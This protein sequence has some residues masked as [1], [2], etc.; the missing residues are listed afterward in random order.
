MAVP[1]LRAAEAPSSASLE[2]QIA[3]LESELLQAQAER[4]RQKQQ[5]EYAD[6]EAIKLRQ[7]AK[8]IEK[9]LIDTRRAYADHML[10]RHEN[11]RTLEDEI[12]ALF[13][14][15]SDAQQEADAIRNEVALAGQKNAGAASTLTA[16]LEDAVT[17]SKD[18]QQQA[19]NK[20]KEFNASRDAAAA[21]DPESAALRKR[22]NELDGRHREAFA[23]LNQYL[24]QR[25]E[26]KSLDRKRMDIAG[27]L[28]DVKKQ[29]GAA[30][31]APAGIQS[32]APAP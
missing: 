10:V 26:I 23:K 25:E 28:A 2:Q 31:A 21:A 29:L 1:L 24:D 13:R 4:F 5:L 3:A 15:S 16:E 30:P 19:I 7:V 17:R 6:P 20:T 18:L 8:T 9:D 14:A 27:Q 12:S 11:L 32:P 22:V